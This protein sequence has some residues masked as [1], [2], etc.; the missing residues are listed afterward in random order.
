MSTRPEL[1]DDAFGVGFMGIAQWIRDEGHDQTAGAPT[2]AVYLKSGAVL[3]GVLIEEPDRTDFL[4]V[5]RYASP[6][7]TNDKSMI[8]TALAWDQIAAVTF[9]MKD[10]D[11]SADQEGTGASVTITDDIEDGASTAALETAT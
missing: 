9:A 4:F 5:S 11:G 1:P 6:E 2:A 7:S 10:Q 3:D 8:V